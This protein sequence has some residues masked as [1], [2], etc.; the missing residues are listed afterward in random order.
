M[1]AEDEH[2]V[3]NDSDIA[4]RLANAPAAPRRQGGIVLRLHRIGDLVEEAIRR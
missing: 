4:H 1:L 3:K 2:A